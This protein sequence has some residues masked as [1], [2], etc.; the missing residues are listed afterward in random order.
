MISGNKKGFILKDVCWTRFFS[1][2]VHTQDYMK[3]PTVCKQLIKSYILIFH[4]N[5]PDCEKSKQIQSPV[6]FLYFKQH[7]TP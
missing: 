4:I 7:D 5:M 2:F 3:E 6:C 1:H